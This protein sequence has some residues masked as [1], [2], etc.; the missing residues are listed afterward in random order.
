MLTSDIPHAL[1][2]RSQGSLYESEVV[3]RHIAG[4][5]DP[6][7]PKRCRE[8]VAKG[9]STCDRYMPM[10]TALGAVSKTA[11]PTIINK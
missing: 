2:P 7:G 8:V 6:P 10:S 11:W 5:K 4:L 3:E 1:W 9:S